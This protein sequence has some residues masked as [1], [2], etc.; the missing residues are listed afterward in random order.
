MDLD[1]VGDVH[2]IHVWSIASEFP[3]MSCHLIVNK[4]VDRDQILQTANEK[5][6]TQFNINHSTI[7]IEGKGSHFHNSCDS[8]V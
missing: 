7:Q 5:I 6:K 3:S 2:D 4:T 1:G 8:Y